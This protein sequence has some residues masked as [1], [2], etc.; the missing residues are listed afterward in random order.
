MPG[1]VE[2]WLNWNIIAKHAKVMILPNIGMIRLFDLTTRHGLRGAHREH[3]LFK[4]WVLAREEVYGTRLFRVETCQRMKLYHHIITLIDETNSPAVS[5]KRKMK[6]VI[7]IG[8]CLKQTSFRTQEIILLFLL[9]SPRIKVMYSSWF[10]RI[11][12]IARIF[13]PSRWYLTIIRH[14]HRAWG[15]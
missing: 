8:A 13:D 3:W 15:E 7:D 4:A 2:A 11:G 9:N 6:H 12:F 10:I 14:I 1:R 5:A